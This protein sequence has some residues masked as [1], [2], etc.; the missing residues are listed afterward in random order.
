MTEGELWL[1]GFVAALVYFVSQQQSGDA[2]GGDA[3]NSI[4]SPF[5]LGFGGGIL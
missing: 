3:G 2:S 1:L 4:A 5:S